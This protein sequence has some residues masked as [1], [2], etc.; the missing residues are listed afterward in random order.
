MIY[1]PYLLDIFEPLFEVTKDPS[2]DPK[3]HLFLKRVVGID[4][5]DDESK[6]E[7]RF[8]KKFP[9][10][11]YWESR[12]NPP[13][14]YYCYYIYSNLAMLNQFRMARGFNLFTF[15]PHSGEAGDPEHLIYSFLTA[16][17]INHGILLRKVP[18]LQYLFYLAQISI[19]MS[20]LSN[21]ALFL[22]FD[23]NPF[24]DYFA[25]GLNVSLSTDDPL[26]FHYTKE[27]L[28]EEYSVA[29][30]IWKLSSVDMCEI[31]RNSVNQ[32]GF[33][34]AIKKYWLGPLCDRPDESSNDVAKSNVPDIRAQF[35]FSMLKAEHDFVRSGFVHDECVNCSSDTVGRSHVLESSLRGEI[36]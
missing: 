21:N 26:Q 22:A 9:F 4:S 28:I 13:Y 1:R 36:E 17:G 35:R 5:V 24:P 19:A 8:H 11:K 31:A 23:R 20:P 10:P 30:Q 27:P 32:S 12:V 25:R 18:A 3:L 6:P 16:W 15:R 29:A 34:L 14:S 7:K 2:I 33:E